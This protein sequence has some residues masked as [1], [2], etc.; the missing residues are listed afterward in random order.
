MKHIIKFCCAMLVLGLASCSKAQIEISFEG[1]KNDMS[2]LEIKL[3]L[4]LSTPEGRR[5]H[6]II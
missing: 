5:A 4:P 6:N 3:Y 1:F 2:I